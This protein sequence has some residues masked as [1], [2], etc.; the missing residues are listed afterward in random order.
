[1]LQARLRAR[2]AAGQEVAMLTRRE[3][4]AGGVVGS[5]AGD[6]VDA[7]SEEQADRAGQRDIE[8]AITRVDQTLDRAFNTVSLSAGFISALRKNF[9]GFIKSNGKFPD[10]CEVGLGVFYEVY[11]WHVR[12]RQPIIVTRQVDNRYTIQFMFTTLLL[13]HENEATY[14]G[15]P[16]DKA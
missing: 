10:F 16:Y 14:I 9:E 7:A 4:L 2:A 12:H 5:L 11:D 3:V 15:Y 8:R 6:S 13:K 1:M